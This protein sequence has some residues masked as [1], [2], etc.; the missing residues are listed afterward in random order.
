MIAIIV[1]LARPYNGGFSVTG[2]SV[3]ESPEA[4]EI[5]LDPV[6]KTSIIVHDQCNVD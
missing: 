6:M 2:D 3:G 4:D 5:S 1:I